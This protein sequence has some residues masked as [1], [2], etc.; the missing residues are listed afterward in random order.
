MIL[1]VPLCSKSQ[2]TVELFYPPPNQWRVEDLWYLKLTNNSYNEYKVHLIGTVDEK[3]AGPIFRGESHVINLPP[4]ITMLVPRDFESDEMDFL[5]EEYKEF[6][7][8][9]GTMKDGDYEV[10]IEVRNAIADTLLVEDCLDLPIQRMM[11]P[12]LLYPMDD[13]AV[14]EPFPVFMWLPPMPLDISFSYEIR[15]E[16]IL[17][18][19][20]ATEALQSIPA[21]F[22]Q[23]NISGTS[24]QLPVFADPFEFG[25]KYA[26][27]ISAY[28]VTGGLKIAESEV[29][30]FNYIEPEPEIPEVPIF[31]CQSEIWNFGNPILVTEFVKG[32]S[33]K[34]NNTLYVTQPL[35]IDQYKILMLK[36][37]LIFFQWDASAECKKCNRNYGDW[38]NVTD[39]A[40]TDH[41]FNSQANKVI[42]A[43]ASEALMNRE[44]YWQPIISSESVYFDGNVTL[45]VSLPPQVDSKLCDDHFQIAIRY[46]IALTDNEFIRFCNFLQPYSFTRTSAVNIEVLPIFERQDH[47]PD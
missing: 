24:F 26:W 22:I 18:D 2:V 47:I 8:K 44:I 25:E 42:S 11:P 36:A 38:G 1:I 9:T 33:I 13:S 40:V 4:G 19:Q 17:H 21:F 15:I 12:E 32:D 27:Q 31:N 37:C 43:T 7:I 30:G 5:N 41:K 3:E 20:T 6:A 23:S 45:E 34:N 46:T 16:Q 39:G 29:W 14:F 10:C 28:D 35:K